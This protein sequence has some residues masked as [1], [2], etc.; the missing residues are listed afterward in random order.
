MLIFPAIDI[1][2]GKA[3]RLYK[4]D[5]AQKTIYADNPIDVASDFVQSGAT[6]MHLVDL[7]GAKSGETPNLETIA[8]IK[9]SVGLF[10]EVGGG[11]RSMRVIKAYT[12]AGID[13]VIIGTAAIEDPVFLNRAL[14]GYADRIAIGADIKDGRIA[15][16]GWTQT[17]D[18]DA[19]SFCEKMQSEGV[20][21]II[22]TDIS[23]D[24]A[25]AGTNRALYSELRKKL[26]LNIIASGGVS[27]IDD[28]RA[29]KEM[30]LY[31][32]IVGKAYYTKDIDLREAIEVA[33]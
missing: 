19:F 4:G 10:C 28:I 20:S 2:E 29:L 6:H 24:G 30:G 17:T 22:C 32:A 15:I 1:F 31:G 7:E 27:S 14:E 23:K 13:R 18:I 9:A 8:S 12:D 33:R 26:S 25:L 5:Y 16:K 3:V 11:V 21:C